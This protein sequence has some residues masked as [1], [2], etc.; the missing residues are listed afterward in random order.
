[1]KATFRSSFLNDLKKVKSAK[2]R[3]RIGD[4]IEEVENAAGLDEISKLK[5][6][7]GAK[8]CYRIRIGDLRL[9]VVIQQD[10]VE[11]VRCLDR[12]DIYKYFPE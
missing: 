7:S 8:D 4:A 1:M 6:L 2:I 12:K 5:K 10:T 11:F 9:G 3:A